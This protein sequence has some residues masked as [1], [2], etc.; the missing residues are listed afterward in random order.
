MKSNL[1]QNSL[2]YYEILEKN[3]GV[4]KTNDI[5]WWQVAN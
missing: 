2:F 4:R 1:F 5:G 3:Q